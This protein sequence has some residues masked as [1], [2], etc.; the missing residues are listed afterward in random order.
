MPKIVD[1]PQWE[2]H[3][4]T[5]E[6]RA[7]KT[8]TGECRFCKQIN[9]FEWAGDKI[10][11]EEDLKEEG[12]RACTCEAAREWRDREY[13][14]AAAEECLD[15]ILPNPEEQTAKDIMKKAVQHIS[16]GGIYSININIG[17]GTKVKMQQAG[18][19]IKVNRTDTNTRQETV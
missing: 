3:F 8:M 18:D 11:S 16:N 2:R 6:R 12:T 5:P 9:A 15:R 17:N 7:M 13:K 10:P 19:A 1:F 14:I 4:E